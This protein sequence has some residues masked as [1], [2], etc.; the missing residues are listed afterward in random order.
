MFLKH[1][2]K[3]FTAEKSYY[4]MGNLNINYLEYFENAKVSTF[5]SYLFK[6]GANVLI[7]KLTQVAKKSA[8]I[9]DNVITIKTFDKSFQSPGSF[10]YFFQLAP[11]NYLKILLHSNLK[12]YFQRK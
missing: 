6:Y 7:N 3:T 10:T 9:I 5:Y 8:T 2:F 12:M 11:P 1:V 4:L